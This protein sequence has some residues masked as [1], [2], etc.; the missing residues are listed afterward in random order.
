LD[1]AVR[2]GREFAS[3]AKAPS[4]S[5]GSM[6]GLK[7]AHS[8]EVGLDGDSGWSSGAASSQT[9]DRKIGAIGI[10]VSRGITS[11]GF[12]FNVTT[13][14]SDFAL[15]NPCGITDKPVTSLDREI[16][17]AANVPSLEIV[18][19]EVARQFGFVFGEELAVLESLDALRAGAADGLA[20]RRVEFPAEDTP[21][22]IPAE[23]ERL[24][25]MVDTSARA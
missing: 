8:S 5:Q 2:P 9:R 1:E 24:R 12:A 23:L 19:G 18:A 15:I 13:N 4:I 21:L 10:H 22:T 20:T 14:L 7:P 11:H 6:N 25:G 16:P 3:G 17:E